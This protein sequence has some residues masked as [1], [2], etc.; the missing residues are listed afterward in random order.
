MKR[1]LILLLLLTVGSGLQAQCPAEAQ[2][3]TFSDCQGADYPLFDLL[4]GGQYVMVHFV[5][6]LTSSGQTANMVEFYHRYGC[7]GR[8]V[9]FVE[10]LL[11][12][13]EATCQSWKETYLLEC[14]VVGA[15]ETDFASLYADCIHY[16]GNNRFLLIA[17]DHSV[18]QEPLCYNIDEVFQ[19]L[20]IQVQDCNFGD[21]PAPADLTASLQGPAIHLSWTG[22][23][24]A[25]YYHVYARHGKDGPFYLVE[26]MTNTYCKA[27]PYWPTKENY[28]YVTT[29]CS[30]G[31]E[32]A[33]DTVAYGPEA[34]D[35]EVVDIHGKPFNLFEVLDQGQYVFV[36]FY[37]YTCGGCRDI[38]KILTKA[39]SHYGCNEKDVFFVEITALDPDTL[40][41]RWVEEFGVEYPTVSRDS[42]GRAFA[43]LY[44][45]SS[46]PHYF[47]V[48]PDHSIVMDGG[49]SDFYIENYQTI[50]DLFHDL[51]IEVHDCGGGVDDLADTQ[52]E[53]FP[54][55]AD[56]FVTVSANGCVCVYNAIGQLINSFVS[57]NQY[58]RIDTSVYP[59]GLYLVH[60]DGRPLG[61][62]VVTH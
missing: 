41:Q 17:P 21:C 24:E 22:C 55:P 19:E 60:V 61:R 57:D 33:S 39:Y 44:S 54:N 46:A 52:A 9:F 8:D 1:L 5:S 27:V 51:D 36:D 35:F 58:T 59:E 6:S 4:D 28:Y 16:T 20:G 31:S 49:V 42:G 53:L 38:V 25:M 13:D 34:V 30:D 18:Y 29:C 2:D 3:Y 32:H 14:P 47:I 45:F 56:D 62:F 26:N 37:N 11:D 40:C 48:A 43:D 15:P 10:M 7:N 50:V 12:M 23:D